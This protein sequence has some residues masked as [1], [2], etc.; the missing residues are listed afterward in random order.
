MRRN[1]RDHWYA[2]ATARAVARLLSTIT[3]LARPAAQQ[4]WL[5]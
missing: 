4:K 2:R 3:A 1:V 5:A